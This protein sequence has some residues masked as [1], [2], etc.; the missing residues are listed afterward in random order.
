MDRKWW[1]LLAVSVAIFMLLLDITVVNVAL[2]DIQRSLHSS[3]QDLQWVVDAYA[4][5]LAAFLLT[6]GAVADLIGRRRVFVA[7][8]VVFTVSSAVCGLSQSPLMLNLARAVQGTGGA[9]MFATSLALIAQAFRGRDRGTAFGVFGA[10]TGA[11]VAVGPLVGG[12]IT[13]GIGWEWVFFVNVPIGVAA[14]IV[15][16]ARV[17]ESRDPG[18]MRVD[19]AG[20]VS[21]SGALFLLVFALVQGN[22]KGWT[23]A[24]ILS[25]LIGAAVLMVAFF[26]VEL[27]Q[28]RPMLDLSLFRRPAFCGASIVAFAIS[29]SLFSMFLYL[30]LYIQ[31]V[32]GYSPLQAGLR[33][34]PV[35]LLSF[36]VAPIAGRLTVKVPIRALLGTGLL[37]VGAGLIAMTAIDA[38]SGWT[39]L[40]PGFLLS[41]AGIGMVNPPLA[42]T[43]IG[44]V[45]PER[46]GMASG[47][48]STFRQVGIA[49]GI[50]GLGAIFQHQV[51]EHTTRALQAGGDVH[52]ILARAHGQLGTLMESG[53]LRQF[54]HTLAPAARSSLNYAYRLGFTEALTDILI[55]SAVVA[56]VGSAL[57]Y[58]LIRS[59][60]FIPSG[61]VPAGPEVERPEPEALGV[62]PG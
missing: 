56:L 12:I 7:G 21:F 9:M 3:F 2:P 17:S 29:A 28:E 16:L 50:A 15:S 24:E 19:W 54:I 14:V 60:D 27:M 40:I 53:G 32:L 36:A 18:A 26:V 49:T 41:G 22:N 35:T 10:V 59:R 5:T 39:T 61:P 44:V 23:S 58:L 4:L 8:L 33:F 13:S 47:I 11:A 55:V 52:E 57:A 37:L 34:L 51:I 1:T 42:S 62:S 48:N 30:T 38:T 43:A 6:A 46:A 31:D 45:P 20:L 25:M